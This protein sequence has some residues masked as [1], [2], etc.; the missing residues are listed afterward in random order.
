M[1]VALNNNIWEYSFANDNVIDGEIENIEK[2]F[3]F[4]NI[5]FSEKPPIEIKLFVS[6][7][8]DGAE[9]VTFID[10]GTFLHI[11][12]SDSLF[13]P[14]FKRISSTI[15]PNF[16]LWLNSEAEKFVSGR[17]HE[18]DSISIPKIAR[19]TRRNNNRLSI[20]NLL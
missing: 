15:S 1:K 19:V 12:D 6:Q 20:E 10:F 2:A 18:I 13:N 16:K 11:L 5:Y 9:I 8:S 7:F 14:D 4:K 17:F 3:E